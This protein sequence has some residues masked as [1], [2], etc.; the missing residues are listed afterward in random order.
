MSLLQST[1]RTTQLNAVGMENEAESDNDTSL[2][3]L[4]GLFCMLELNLE[5]TLF[6]VSFA[7]I[8]IQVEEDGMHLNSKY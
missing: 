8:T 2:Y 6:M 5:R 4:F 7:T 1:W 3:Q